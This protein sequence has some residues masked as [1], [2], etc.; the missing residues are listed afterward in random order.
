MNVRI[1]TVVLVALTTFLTAHAAEPPKQPN[2]VVF[3]SDDQILNLYPQHQ[4]GT[5]IDRGPVP[6]RDG[7][8]YWES[9]VEAAKTNAKAAAVVKRYRDRPAEEL[10]DLTADPHEQ[11]NLAADPQHAD[12]LTILR[13]EL[14]AWMTQQGDNKSFFGRPTLLR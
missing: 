14:D 11:T 5:H 6:D 2:I 4:Y 7:V 13:R 10:Y 1:W 3:I 8:P 12:R 9:W